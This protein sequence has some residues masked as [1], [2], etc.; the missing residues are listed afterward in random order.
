ML[1]TLAK[2]DLEYHSLANVFNLLDGDE[3]A[4][5][6]EDVKAFGLIE[7]I[8]LLDGEILDGRNRYRAC[9][10]ACIEPEFYAFS[11]SEEIYNGFDGNY[12]F[13][14]ALDN[15]V[16]YV[17]S[18]NIKR[19]H[20]NASQRAMAAVE[21][22]KYYAEEARKRQATSTGGSS[23][24]T[25]SSP[26]NTGKSQL[27]E[28]L[29]EAGKG[30]ARDQAG[31]DLQVS[32]KMVDMAET[33][34]NNA[35]PEIKAAVVNGDLAVSKAAPVARLPK[36]QQK[37]ALAKPT[38]KPS[39]NKSLD[40][41]KEE[42][43]KEREEKSEMRDLIADLQDLN[44]ELKDEVNSQL[45]LTKEQ[46]QQLVKFNQLRQRIRTLES[47]RDD[48]MSQVNDWKRKAKAL[49]RKLGVVNG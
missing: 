12:R 33:V 26:E 40:K 27:Q 21:L 24:K 35:I 9:K 28:N 6:V 37:E 25:L 1:N 13:M 36:E 8:A 44:G 42:L 16:A 18:R 32:G 10:A 30:Q 11:E 17:V 45:D 49:E 47:Q 20:L 2:S 39:G 43:V 4:E 41:L 34:T 29:P 7:P 48:L 38:I 19:R 15:P 5:L 14:G 3:F 46:Q 22:K 31:R 23:P